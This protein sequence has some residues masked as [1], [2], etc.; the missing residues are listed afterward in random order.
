MLYYD[1]DDDDEFQEILYN[2]NDDTTSQI[3]SRLSTKCSLN[4]QEQENW[5]AFDMNDHI[6]ENN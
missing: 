6:M 5:E 2:E 4:D 1:N 3:G